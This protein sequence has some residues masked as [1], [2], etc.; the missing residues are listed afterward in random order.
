MGFE[1]EGIDQLLA[2][3]VEREVFAG[4]SAI[5]VDRDGVLYN[6]VAGEA[7][8]DTMFRNASMTKAPATVGALQLVE[9]GLLELDATVE[10][11]LPEFGELQVLDGFDGDIPRLREPASKATVRQLMTHTSGCGYFFTNENLNRYAELTGLASPLTGLKASMMG[12]LAR[13]P[14]TLWEYGVSTDWLGLVVEAVSGQTLDVYLTEHLFGPLEMSDT[15]FSP[16]AE[17]RER[18]MALKARTPEG[19]LA[20]LDL[21]LP[22]EPEWAAAGHGSYGTV[23]DYGRFIRAMLCDGELESERVLKAETVELAFSNHIEGIPLPS[24]IKSADPMISND[25]P[26]LPLPQGWGLGFHL[27]EVD[28]PGGRAKGTGDWAGIFNSYF[29]IDRATG[30]GGAIMTQVL[31][32]FDMKI[33]ETLLGFEG[34]TYAQ[35]RNA[36]A[37]A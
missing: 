8:T 15:T 1:G 27:L 31:P 11:I 26:M 18:L 7:D 3:A 5:V 14:G 10:S 12:P 20:P 35:V 9:Q 29:W 17:Q 4:V 13:D 16:T 33:V 32:F 23:G 34:A 6:G 36:T 19:G 2:A 21:D 30:I 22:G 25:I 28:I 24:L 37:A